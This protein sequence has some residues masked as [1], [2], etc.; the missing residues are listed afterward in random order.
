[1][2]C[3]RPFRISETLRRTRRATTIRTT[4][5]LGSCGD[6]ALH[7]DQ[8]RLP[9][10]YGGTSNGWSST[11]PATRASSAKG[12][13]TARSGGTTSSTSRRRSWRRPEPKKRERHTPDTDEGVSWPTPLSDAKAPSPHHPVLRISAPRRS[14]TTA[15]WPGTVHRAAVGIQGR[16]RSK[17]T[18]G[19]CTTRER[20]S[21][22]NDLPLKTRGS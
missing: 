12:R 13:V 11:G 22:W 5:R 2:G 18:S 21:V 4:R 20:I 6:Y 16:G 17:K 9:R 19:S 14:T 15:G 10:G 3:P 8:S 1:M 7:L